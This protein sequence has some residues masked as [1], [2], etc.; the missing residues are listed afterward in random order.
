[1]TIVTAAIIRSEGRILIARRKSGQKLE[2]FWEFPGGKM[3]GEESPQECLSRELY[4]EFGVTARV[5]EILSVSDY[6]YDHGT[7]RLLA[8]D[9]LDISGD[10]HLTVHDRIEWVGADTIL[11]CLLA[12]ADIKIAREYSEGKW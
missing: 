12:P 5:G 4:E 1:M 8:L 11:S 7:I 3:E 10:Y 2:G 9:V 6:Q